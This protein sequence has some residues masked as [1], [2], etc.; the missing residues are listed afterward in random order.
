MRIA[1]GTLKKY[2]NSQFLLNIETDRSQAKIESNVCNV[3]SVQLK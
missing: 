2:M 1:V 3:M